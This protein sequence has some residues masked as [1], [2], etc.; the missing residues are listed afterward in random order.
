MSRRGHH[1]DIQAPLFKHRSTREHDSGHSHDATQR[2]RHAAV[3]NRSPQPKTELWTT[4]GKCAGQTE[5]SWP[6]WA[7]QRNLTGWQGRSP[8]HPPGHHRAADFRSV[9]S[10]GSFHAGVGA[11]RRRQQTFAKGHA[12]PRIEPQG[13]RPQQGRPLPATTKLLV[14]SAGPGQLLVSGDK[15]GLDPVSGHQ[16]VYGQ[17]HLHHLAHGCPPWLPTRTHDARE[18]KSIIGCVV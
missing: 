5:A 9:A 16:N 15:I 11:G 2:L 13:E 17:K 3:G 4:K 8:G 7:A 18:T 12:S 10:N 14:A 6:T 1:G